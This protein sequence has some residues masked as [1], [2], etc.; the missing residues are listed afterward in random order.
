MR[1][2]KRALAVLTALACL[3]AAPHAGATALARLTLEAGSELVGDGAEP[4]PLGGW[5]ELRLAALPGD[6]PVA[7]EVVRLVVYT[8]GILEFRLDPEIASPGL[9]VLFPDGS[10]LIPTLFLVAGTGVARA[11][12]A[13]P[14]I[15]GVLDLSDPAQAVLEVGFAV[16]QESETVGV[17]IVAV[18]EPGAAPLAAAAALAAL[19]RTHSSRRASGT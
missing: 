17:S 11:P 14:D 3:V 15:E 1:H 13:L 4:V 10:F 18:P 7:L 9:G 16:E 8:G 5:I 12:L 19:A 6:A 2:P